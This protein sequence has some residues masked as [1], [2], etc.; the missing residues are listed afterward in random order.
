[1]DGRYNISKFTGVV[2]PITPIGVGAG[3]AGPVLA[4]PRFR[5][6][7]KIPY[8]RINSLCRD[9]ADAQYVQYLSKSRIAL[10][11]IC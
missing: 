4:G 8:R 5:R 1:M 7:N 6:F 11:Q 2:L 9:G 10:L 3:P